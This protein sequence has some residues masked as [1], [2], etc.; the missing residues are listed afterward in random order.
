M[1]VRKGRIERELVTVRAWEVSLE[2]YARPVLEEAER[3][4]EALR[5][6]G[7]IVKGPMCRSL[8][9]GRL[10]CRILVE[11]ADPRTAR[12]LGHELEE[13]RGDVEVEVRESSI[14]LGYR[15]R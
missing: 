15:Y 11:A 7:V 4:K 14:R 9:E 5:R 12:V 1:A 3:I 8:G 2:G 10:R 13:V 6:E